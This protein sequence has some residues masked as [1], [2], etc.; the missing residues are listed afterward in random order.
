MGPRSHRRVLGRIKAVLRSTDPGLAAM[1]DSFTVRFAGQAMPRAEHLGRRR[2]A[3]PL[4]VLVFVIGALLVAATT[5]FAIATT[6]PCSGPAPYAKAPRL[7]A[8]RG[9]TTVRVP[10]SPSCKSGV[11]AP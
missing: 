6:S 2:S 9:V 5:G 3:R 1:F 7:V 11:R 8:T 4:A 10:T